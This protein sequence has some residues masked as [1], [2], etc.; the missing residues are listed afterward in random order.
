[1]MNSLMRFA[2]G[3]AMV[4]AMA[5]SPPAGAAGAVNRGNSFTINFAAARSPGPLDGR[6]ILLLSRDFTREPRSHVAAEEPLASP[7]LF[8]LNVEG[9]VPGRAVVMDEAVELAKVF[10]TDGSASFVNGVLSACVEHL[11]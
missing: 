1:M 3:A 8:G 5:S 10:S 7:Y 9:W 4:C 11:T 2:A 6:V